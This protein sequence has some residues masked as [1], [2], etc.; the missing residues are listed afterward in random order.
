MI[1]PSAISPLNRRVVEGLPAFSFDNA[2]QF[3]GVNDYVDF[4]EIN[5]SD[6][7]TI[8]L[9]FKT[10]ETYQNFLITNSDG[11]RGLRITST[12]LTLVTLAGGRNLTLGETIILYNWN[13]IFITRSSTN[14]INLYVNGIASTDNGVDFG[15][16]LPLS[17]FGRRGSLRN[18]YIIDEIAIWNKELISTDGLGLFNNGNGDFATNYSPNDLLS[19]WRCNEIDG[20]TTLTDEQGTYDGTL[21]NFSTPPAYFIPH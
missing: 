3:D 5:F 21:T 14:V 15:G 2:L 16:S 19:Y 7:F 4:T 13:H 18:N 9:W 11:N 12:V 1:S 20:A 17:S 10:S 6:E 8:S